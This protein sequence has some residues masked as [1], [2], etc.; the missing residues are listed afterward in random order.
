MT[1]H[2][3]QPEG[4]QHRLLQ[5]LIDDPVA[6][7]LLGDAQRRRNRAG[8]APPRPPR[9]P[10]RAVD[11]ADRVA[12]LEG[13]STI[14]RSWA[15]SVIET[16]GECARTLSRE[17]RTVN[18]EPA[19]GARLAR[20]RPRPAAR[21]RQLAGR[22]AAALAVRLMRDANYPWLLLVPRRRLYDRDR[23]PRRRRTAQH[24]DGRRS[25]QA[26][27]ALRATVACDKLNVAALGNVVP[28]LHVHVIARPQRRRGLA[29]AGLGRGPGEGLR[30]RA[31]QRRLRRS[32]R[33][34]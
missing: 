34:A 21:G 27:D 9:A 33:R 25:S 19:G 3:V 20:L 7:L 10:R 32:S 28:Q 2:V 8:R 5:P 29:E 26:S 4:Q 23:R 31:R 22:R 11:D 12:R 30:R 24:A 16:P 13:A 1:C 18:R 15:M 17:R 6:V 14:E